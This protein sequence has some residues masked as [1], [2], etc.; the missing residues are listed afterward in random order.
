[1]ANKILIVEDDWYLLATLGYNLL[2][3]GYSEIIAVD[4]AQVLEIARKF[5]GWCD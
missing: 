1:M 2:R 5:N 3:E 4:G